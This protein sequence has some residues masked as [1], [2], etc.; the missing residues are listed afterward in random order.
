M[1]DS[2]LVLTNVRLASDPTFFPHP[3]DTTKHRS[4]VTVIK[5]HG[6]NRTT[7]L[8]RK[9]TEY[10]LTFWGPYAQTCALYL[11]KGRAINVEVAPKSYSRET[12]RVKPTGAKEI[13][14]TTTFDVKSFEFSLDSKKELV[15]R[16]NTNLATA[17]AQ[18]RLNP[19]ATITAEELILVVRPQA[20]DYNPAVAAQTGMY[21]NAKV[22]IKGA[23]FLGGGHVAG[24]AGAVPAG[25]NDALIAEMQARI[26]ALKAAIVPAPAA[27]TPVVTPPVATDTAV[28]AFPE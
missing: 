4:L 7:G 28:A 26:D 18:G 27:E 24:A 23:G 10:S 5:N 21:G 16:I 3:T 22:Y 11:A 12:G 17:K 14:R 19:D 25:N 2:K 20:Y 13:N 9:P 8:E 1:I 6:K 15:K